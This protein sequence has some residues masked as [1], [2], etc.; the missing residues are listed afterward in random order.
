MRRLAQAPRDDVPIVNRQ[1]GHIRGVAQVLQQQLLRVGP[2]ERPLPRQQFLIDD[3]QTVLVA[4]PRH[5][6]FERFRAG[7][8][9]RDPAGD[10][11]AGAFESFGQTEVGDFD[12]VEHQEQILR[13]DVEVLDLIMRV[14]QIERFG[15]FVHVPQQF[16]AR[17]SHQARH[18]TLAETIPKVAVGQLHDDNELAID[19]VEAFERED[20]RVADRLDP[21]Q[22]LQF[23]FGGAAFVLGGVQIPEH[24]L[25]RFKEPTGGFDLPNFAE[26][27]ATE[28][29]DQA[30]ATELLRQSTH[31]SGVDGHAD[32]FRKRRPGLRESRGARRRLRIS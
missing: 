9:G 25:H 2:V 16:I 7:V 23:L 13:L 29:L 8:N 11:C 4:V 1:R 5:V 17:N 24:E 27:A 26:T 20:I 18:P 3:R 10:G 6:P 28:S 21:V 30:V 22:S 31:R 15:R 12:V 19:D 14:H 32:G